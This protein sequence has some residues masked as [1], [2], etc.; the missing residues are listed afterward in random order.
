MATD[1]ELQRVAG[2]ANKLR[3][4][5]P[6]KSVL[7]ILRNHHADRVYA[8][9]AVA[10]AALAAD[11]ETETPARL[12]EPGHW[13][14]ATRHNAGRSTVPAVG[15]GRGKRRCDRAGHEH[16]AAAACRLCRAEIA[17]GDEPEPARPATDGPPT[18]WRN[19]ALRSA[20]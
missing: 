3:P 17:A 11:P 4:E 9:L 15:P 2:A 19:R 18:D 5:W 12:G 20:S 1:A 13:W 7:T 8:D 6:A 16:E 10:V 14:L